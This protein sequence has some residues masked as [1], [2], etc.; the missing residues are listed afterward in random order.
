MK[1][2]LTVSEIAG[3]VGSHNKKYF[4]KLFYDKFGMKPAKYRKQFSSGG[5]YEKYYYLYKG[6]YGYF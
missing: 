6:K 1:I 3:E 4:Y 2:A 5:R